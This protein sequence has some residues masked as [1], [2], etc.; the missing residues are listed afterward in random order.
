MKNPR[1]LTDRDISLDQLLSV[2]P[3]HYKSYVSKGGYIGL[4]KAIGQ[5]GRSGV[6]EAVK[7]SGLRGRGG[8]GFPTWKKWDLVTKQQEDQHYLCCNAAE[9]EPGTFKD[10]LLLRSNPHQIIE[11]TILS[12]YAI[13]AKEA[14]LYINGQY[15]EEIQFM[16]EA[17]VEAK[18]Q[19]HW[20]NGSS[21]IHSD[22]S[23][24][25]C[26]SPGTYVAGE[27]TALLEVIEGKAAAPRQKPPYYPAMHGLFGKPTV[28]NNAESVSNIPGIVRD[29]GSQFRSVGTAGSSGTMIFTLTGDVN[30]PGLYERPLGTPMRELVEVCGGG[31]KDG[32]KL[33]AFFPG[34]PSTS[35]LPADHIDIPLDFDR[36]KESGSA[37]GTGAVIVMSENTCILKAAIQYTR[38][39]AKESC[40]QCP[41]CELGTVHLAEILEKIEYGTGDEKDIAQVEQVCN[42][43]KGRGQCFLL[44]GAAISVESIF[45]H[46]RYEFDHHVAIGG[47][48]LDSNH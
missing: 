30:K 12:A 6:L 17:L 31:M 43:I 20:G 15:Q 42:M 16:E 27:E 33:K 22:V 45:K 37:L 23:L 26:Q 10:R 44:T 9:D 47:C 34:G 38:F 8:A 5:M 36:L 39:F 11:G 28:V 48:P 25:L 4:S 21:E 29:G 7:T 19:G 1:I 24:K 46:F 2:K 18:A 13:G 40:G 32:T 41:P 35:I 3:L 14:Y